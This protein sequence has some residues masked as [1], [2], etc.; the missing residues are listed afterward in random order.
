[1]DDHVPFW[2]WIV[3][4]VAIIVCFFEIYFIMGLDI[5]TW[6]KW[7]ILI[8]HQLVCKTPLFRSRMRSD[9]SYGH[10]RVN[11]QPILESLVGTLYKNLEDIHEC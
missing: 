8:R 4:V 9:R 10:G 5:P 11:T 3:F 6:A 7:L 2:F 1:M